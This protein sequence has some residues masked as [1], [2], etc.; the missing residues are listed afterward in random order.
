MLRSLVLAIL[1][2]AAP[3][4]QHMHAQGL[5]GVVVETY[6]QQRIGDDTLTTYRIW[7]DLAE[8]HSLQ[9]VFGSVDHPLR[10]ETTTEFFNDTVHGVK[11]A[12]RLDADLLDQWPLA[13]DS[14]LTVSAASDKHHAVPLDSDADG[15]VLRAKKHGKLLRSRDGLKAADVKQV[16]DFKMDPGYLG[17]IRGGTILC[18]DCAWSVLGGIMGATP[19]N[20][21]LIAQISTTGVLSYELNVHVGKQGGGFLRYV[22]VNPQGDE[23]LHEALRK[24]PARLL[25]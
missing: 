20:K 4:A 1:L 10:I 23:V 17:N 2:H 12:D 13:Y 14:W 21:V 16:V 22:G 8:H 15:S 18:T 25:P 7:I 5:E 19:E 9:M 24:L 11:Y 3:M 6:H